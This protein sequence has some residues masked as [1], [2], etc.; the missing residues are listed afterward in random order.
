MEE[1]RNPGESEFVGPCDI[2]ARGWTGHNGR[3]KAYSAPEGT[4]GGAD[5]HG[6]T[7]PKRKNDDSEGES[8][9]GEYTHMLLIKSLERLIQ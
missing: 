8:D 5:I 2:S 9:I 6:K 1:G 7:I 4:T 3:G